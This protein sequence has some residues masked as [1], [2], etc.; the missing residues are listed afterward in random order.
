MRDYKNAA[1]TLKQALE[2]Q[3]DNPRLQAGLAQ[4]PDV[5]RPGGRGARDLPEALRPKTPPTCSL[6]CAWRRSTASSTTTSRRHEALK[7]AKAINPQD[8]EVR[9]EEVRLLE[10]QSKYTE[11]ISLLKGW[12]TK[13]SR[14]KYSARRRRREAHCWRNWAASIGRRAVHRG[15]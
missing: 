9:Y 5:E 1:E 11:A 10:A 2:M 8:M 15:R 12:W 3:P 4:E 6:S 13:P 7:K 14:P